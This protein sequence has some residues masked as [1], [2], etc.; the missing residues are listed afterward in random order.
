MRGLS[1]TFLGTRG[2]ID[3]RS[4]LHR[5]HSSLLVRYHRAR[6]MIDCGRD[7]L[8]RV[9]RV[10]PT[11]IVLTHAHPDHARGLANGAPCPVYAT[12]KTW[13]LLSAFP[14]RDRRTVPMRKPVAI[15][16]MKF[17]AF[18]VRH[19]VRAPAVGYRVSANGI[20][21]FYVPDVVRIDNSRRA[22]RGIDL[23]IG[24]GAAIRR[25]L[26]RRRKQGLIGH[27]SIRKQLAWCRR[28]KVRRA[29]FT[30]CGSEI[31][32]G[33]MRTMDQAVRAMG[34]RY[35]V[36]ARIAHDG[37]RL[38]LAKRNRSMTAGKRRRTGR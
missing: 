31:V 3:A 25:S 37:Q 21:F 36:E 1:L 2:E 14:I 19:S 20:E 10:R 12:R 23:Y 30:H 26:I 7:W 16:G 5:R 11:A 22:L 27:A 8:N 28:E 9:A 34:A 18:P 24:D 32:K 33:E 17:V 13:R 38:H 4:H 6:V 29:I 15:G 35:D